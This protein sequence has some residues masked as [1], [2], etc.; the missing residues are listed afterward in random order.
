M[1]KLLDKVKEIWPNGQLSK[2]RSLRSLGRELG[3]RS[4]REFTRALKKSKNFLKKFLTSSKGS[5]FI[6]DFPLT[7]KCRCGFR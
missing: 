6:G 7:R 3:D 5:A 1:K 4:L 2:L